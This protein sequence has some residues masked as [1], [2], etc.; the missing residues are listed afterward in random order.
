MNER[1]ARA[2]CGLKSV[3]QR[4]PLSMRVCSLS[5][6]LTLFTSGM[7]SR[8]M[9]VSLGDMLVLSLNVIIVRDKD[10]VLRSF[11]ILNYD[12]SCVILGNNLN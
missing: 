3:R 5:L 10:K 4:F 8:C 7:F 1:R 11:V 12:G 6:A 9:C 2:R